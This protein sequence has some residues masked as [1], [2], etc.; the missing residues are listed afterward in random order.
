[1]KDMGEANMI[2]GI[3]I[4][5]DGN[6]IKLSQAHYIE[7]ALKRFNMFDITP[8]STLMDQHVKLCRY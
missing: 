6:G 1:M 4:I 7:K 5:R 3:K 2:L 8:M